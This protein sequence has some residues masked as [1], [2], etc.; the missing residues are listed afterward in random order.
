MS[1]AVDGARSTR[2]NHFDDLNKSPKRSRPKVKETPR[3]NGCS[4]FARRRPGVG[5]PPVVSGRDERGRCED[6][7]DVGPL[8]TCCKP[9]D[10]F[11]CDTSGLHVPLSFLEWHKKLCFSS[12]YPGWNM[13]GQHFL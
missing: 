9:L 1:E 7:P 11:V 10:I 6:K 2:L 4:K 12:G 5:V 13:S 3:R 8:A